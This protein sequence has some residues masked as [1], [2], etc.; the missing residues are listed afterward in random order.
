[1]QS[2][3]FLRYI[4]YSCKICDFLRFSHSFFFG[5]IMF[6]YRIQLQYISCRVMPC[7][8][9]EQAEMQHA[10]AVGSLRACATCWAIS[11]QQCS[12]GHFLQAT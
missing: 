10:V 6:I 2:S 7:A 4:F 9:L 3:R 1:M 12:C 8:R 11:A 5:K